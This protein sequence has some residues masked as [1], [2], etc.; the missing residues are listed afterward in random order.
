[1]ERTESVVIQVAPSYENQK[2]KEME[3]FGWNLQNRQEVHQEGDAYG[4]PSYMDSSTY[5]VKV[6]VSHYVKLHFVRALSLP[7]LQKIKQLEAEYENLAFPP[8]AGLGWPIGVTAFFALG[9][10]MAVANSKQFP[11]PALL[12]YVIG[13][14][15]GAF[16]ISR[17][18]KK[19][20]AAN[21]QQ[22]R[23]LARSQEILAEVSKLTT[24]VARTASAG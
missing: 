5:I 6:K 4:R 12:T 20:T 10:V 24:E 22:S 3:T 21:D 17:R 11:L 2:I 23:S 7:N 14:A 8:L 19:R 13:V 9:A 1:M 18:L 16:W 15:L